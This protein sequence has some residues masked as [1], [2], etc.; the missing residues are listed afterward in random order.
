MVERDLVDHLRYGRPNGTHSPKKVTTKGTKGRLAEEFGHE[1]MAFNLVDFVMFNGSTTA[2]YA[3]AAQA[4]I[5]AIQNRTCFRINSQ[6]KFTSFEI[7]KSI[8]YLRLL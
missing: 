8:V 5:I 2:C 1:F 3:A 6:L 4:E 7:V